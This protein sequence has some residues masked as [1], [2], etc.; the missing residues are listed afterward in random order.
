[1][2][3]W[4][5]GYSVLESLTRN[6]H[7]AQSK[8]VVAVVR[9]VVLTGSLRSLAV[10]ETL[11][12]H[13]RGRL[14]K[15]KY[16]VQRFYRL[17][18]NRKLDDLAVWSALSERLLSLPHR[19]K[20]VSLDW[21]EWGTD[22]RVLALTL[23]VGKRALPLFVQA[24]DKTD[25]PRSQNARENAFVE[26]LEHLSP[27]LRRAILL[28]DRGFHRATFVRVLQGLKQRF[29]VRLVA[30]LAVEG[31][32]S[33]LLSEHPLR[34]GQVVDL[35]VVTLRAEKKHGPVRVRIIGV[36]AKGQKEPWWIATSLTV[37]PTR[38]AELYD[39]RMSIE[40]AFRD[41][42][43][44]RY[45]MCMKWTAFTRPERLSRLFLLATL[46]MLV[47]TIV[48][49]VAAERDPSL[50]L[51][52]RAKGPRR[53][54]ISIGARAVSLIRQ[55]LGYHVSRALRWLLP[56]EPRRFPWMP[57]CES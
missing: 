18:W 10:A 48:G 26:V 1:M 24:F 13:C 54:L 47:W 29:A 28:A 32:W 11:W 42:K 37:A 51:T 34:P 45:G 43:G 5:Q 39:R 40:E 35:G 7:R 52:S 46:A 31:R 41:S 27:L 33:G 49:M 56:V 38:V 6:L 14:S 12:D 30:K 17:V 36:W 21:T 4:K 2:H 55:V 8:A 50:R 9:A 57:V 25:M 3:R 20:V 15:Y 22:N 53:S 44:A 16:A 23:S 19:L